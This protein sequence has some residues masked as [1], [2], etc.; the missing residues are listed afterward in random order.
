MNN[1]IPAEAIEAANKAV[2][3]HFNGLIRPLLVQVVLESAAPRMLEEAFEQG[4]KSGIR[5]ATRLAAAVRM[6]R[7]DLPGPMS[8]NPYRTTR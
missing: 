2:F 6:G 3:H 8:P 5:H 4:Q 7:P 1:P